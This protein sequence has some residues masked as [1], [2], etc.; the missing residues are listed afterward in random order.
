MTTISVRLEGFSALAASLGQQARQIPFA[1]S[2]ALNAT[3]RTIRA[4][5]LAE[6]AGEDEELADELTRPLLLIHGLADDNVVAAHT[7]QMSNALLAAGKPHEVLPL[8]GVT[9]MTPQE[10]VAE[11]RALGGALDEARDVGQHEAALALERDEQAACDRLARIREHAADGGIRTLQHAAGPQR[12]IDQA[13]VHA[14]AC[15]RGACRVAATNTFSKTVMPPN[16]RW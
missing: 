8:V 9:H 14:C 2:Q 3:A 6:M 5:T 12:E 7:L 16:G 4:A 13:Q 11:P 10:V 1:A 15:V